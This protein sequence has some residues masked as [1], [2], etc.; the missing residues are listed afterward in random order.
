MMICMDKVDQNT[1]TGKLLYAFTSDLSAS[2]MFGQTDDFYLANMIETFVYLCFNSLY[3]Y[4]LL[5]LVS[6][7][8][9]KDNSSDKVYQDRIPVSRPIDHNNLY[10]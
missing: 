10:V 3:T 6:R 1:N 2:G 7:L 8:A 9:S 5:W 4:K